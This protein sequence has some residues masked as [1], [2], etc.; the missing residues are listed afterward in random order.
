[1]SD[2]A[3]T[4]SK[5]A[6]MMYEAGMGE[7]AIV[8]AV[9]SLKPTAHFDGRPYFDLTTINRAIRSHAVADAPIN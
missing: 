5:A 9:A 1:M 7:N 8:S 2:I 4:A 6:G 3:V